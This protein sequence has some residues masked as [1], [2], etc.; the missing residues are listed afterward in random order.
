MAK[1]LITREQYKNIK[2]KDHSQM[3][4]YL[5]KVWQDGFNEGLKQAR[6]KIRQTL[7]RA[8]LKRQ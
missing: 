2:K 1:N 4:D 8:T 7:S 6:K 5:T 3:S